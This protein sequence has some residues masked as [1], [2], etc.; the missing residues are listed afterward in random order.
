[1]TDWN[2]EIIRICS[3]L[4]Q[5]LCSTCPNEDKTG[6]GQFNCKT[7]MHVVA[8]EA[9]SRKLRA[10]NERYRKALEQAI[11]T[12]ESEPVQGVGEWETG[13]FCGLEDMDITDRYQAFRSGYDKAL[14]KVQEWIIDGLNQTLQGS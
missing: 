10:E 3:G 8:I 14:D 13:M 6:C 1:M 12:M 4:R 9:M 5:R 11:K 7:I 2:K